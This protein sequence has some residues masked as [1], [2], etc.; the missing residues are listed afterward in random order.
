MSTNSF[1]EKNRLSSGNSSVD[2]SGKCSQISEIDRN[3]VRE[4]ALQED[5]M[6]FNSLGMLPVH[7]ELL[8]EAFIR[9][10]TN[11]N[12]VLDAN[13]FRKMLVGFGFEISEEEANNLMSA[14]DFDNDGEISLKELNNKLELVRT[15]IIRKNLRKT[16]IYE[17]LKLEKRK[18]IHFFK[19][20]SLLT[21]RA[22][23]Q[24]SREG[25]LLLSDILIVSIYALLIGLVYSDNWD[26]T[27]FPFIALLSTLG[28]STI[29]CTASVRVFGSERLNFWREASVGINT[30]AYFV[31]K[32]IVGFLPLSCYPFAFAIIFFNLIAPEFNFW[33][34]YIIS[35]LLFWSN[36]GLGILLSLTLS[37]KQASLASVM[38][39][40]VIGGFFSGVFP[41]W[42]SM[43]KF[44]KAV[45][46]V[47]HTRWASNA[48]IIA[49]YRGLEEHV[50]RDGILFQGFPIDDNTF[51]N[52][53]IALFLLGL[54][55]RFLAYVALFF[56][57]RNKRK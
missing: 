10:D 44:L 11:N 57:N 35:L 26:I 23:L 46:A 51:R 50:P 19:T 43:S 2:K 4:L 15:K 29:A 45:C 53:H 55:Y 1:D 33:I 54:G 8:R 9:F 37:P 49:E 28:Y 13:E 14:L 39:P 38:A 20:L 36:S 16:V 25:L 32:N 5:D 22:L 42:S 41:F 24:F 12:G 31:S 52:C 56:L 30:F 21:H 48:L 34:L 40:L 7:F 18:S 3:S 47:S 27:D 17:N 6:D